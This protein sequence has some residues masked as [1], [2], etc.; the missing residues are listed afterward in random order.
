MRIIGIG[1][2]VAALVLANGAM[3]NDGCGGDGTPD[4]CAHCGGHRP[5]QPKVC[6]VV[7]E[8]KKE[9]RHCWCVEREDF[10][11]TLPGCGHGKACRDPG[12]GCSDPRCDGGCPKCQQGPVP[13]KC[14][15]PCT[16]KK[17]V[18]REYE[19]EIPVYKCVVKYLCCEC[20][21]GAACDEAGTAN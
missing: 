20:D 12:C 19:V 15:K 7:C 1:V 6:Q 9:K 17:L 2:F 16:R 11:I 5:C 4:C 21:G 14:G 8:I 18:K 10:C 13:P 3:A